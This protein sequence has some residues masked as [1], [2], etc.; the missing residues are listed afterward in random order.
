M[1]KKRFISLKLIIPLAILFAIVLLIFAFNN[2]DR[3][4]VDNY[5]FEHNMTME[6][7][8][9]DLDIHGYE[10]E[11]KIRSQNKHIH[12]YRWK[13]YDDIIIAAVYTNTWAANSSKM[14]PEPF[15]FTVLCNCKEELAKKS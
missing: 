15:N 12:Y 11:E 14:I 8:G 1:K 3:G 10:N 13:D 4:F 6:Y 2:F 9:T 5:F 7:I